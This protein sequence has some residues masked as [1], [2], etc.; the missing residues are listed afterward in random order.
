M[1]K[2]F[3]T[4]RDFPRI[5]ASGPLVK[6]HVELIK[7]QAPIYQ[8]RLRS[9]QV[10]A[11]LQDLR[12]LATLWDGY[13][14]DSINRALSSGERCLLA[15]AEFDKVVTTEGYRMNDEKAQILIGIRTNCDLLTSITSTMNDNCMELS[16]DV[17][18]SLRGCD[19]FL[20]FRVFL[21]DSINELSSTLF[22]TQ[23]ALTNI[24]ASIGPCRR[25][26]KIR[27]VRLCFLQFS[28]SG[29]VSFSCAY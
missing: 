4:K 1:F 5:S 26:H 13:F 12:N 3:D 18:P 16:Q 17:I 6:T 28:C 11:Q 15:L 7:T 21:S 24:S 23:S 27:R 8:Q 14:S 25:H 20:E 29:A 19:Q 2:T 10:K 9:Y 22:F